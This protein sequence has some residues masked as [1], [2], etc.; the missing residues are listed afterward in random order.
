MRRPRRKRSQ[1]RGRHVRVHEVDRPDAD[2]VAP[3]GRCARRRR[4]TNCSVELHLHS[5]R[6]A[7]YNLD[8]IPP[9]RELVRDTANVA[10]DTRESIAPH[11]LDDS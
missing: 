7:A 2:E 10:L 5:R 4:V 9:R 11:G 6:V 3:D 8:H 1:L